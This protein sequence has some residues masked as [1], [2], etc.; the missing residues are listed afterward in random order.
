MCLEQLQNSTESLAIVAVTQVFIY[1]AGLTGS[2]LFTLAHI[3]FSAGGRG[4][5]AIIARWEA[6]Y[7]IDTNL[8]EM[9]DLVLVWWMFVAC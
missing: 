1:G 3:A 4:C 2:Q 6:R 5:E 8:P 7:F 9:R